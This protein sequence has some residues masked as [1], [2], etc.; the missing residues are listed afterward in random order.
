M[1]GR[2]QVGQIIDFVH[3]YVEGEGHVM[4]HDFKPIVVQDNRLGACKKVA[5]AD[6]LVTVI[7]QP[8]AEVGAKKTCSAGDCNLLGSIVVIHCSL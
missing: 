2:G 3:L 6:D 4:A 5:D 8:L 7:E 1:N